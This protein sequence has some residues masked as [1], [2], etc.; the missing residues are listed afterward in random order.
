MSTSC[1]NSLAKMPITME[2]LW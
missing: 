2:L 1:R